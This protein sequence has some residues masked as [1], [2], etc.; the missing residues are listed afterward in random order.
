MVE[1]YLQHFGFTGFPFSINAHGHELFLSEQYREAAAQMHYSLQHPGGIIVLTGE[2]GTGKTTL[3]RNFLDRQAETVDTAFIVNPRMPTPQ[4]IESI[5]QELGAKPRKGGG[6]KTNLDKLHQYLLKARQ[7]DR[8][9][10]VLVDEAQHLTFDSLEQLRLLTNLETSAG[11]LAQIIL[12]GQEELRSLLAHP[13]LRQ[14]RQRVVGHFHLRRLDLQQTGAYIRHRLGCANGSP[15]LIPTSLHRL[16]YRHTTGVPRLINLLCD[17]ALLG[18]YALGRRQVDRGVM[19]Q[20][21]AEMLVKPGRE[22]II[23]LQA[24]DKPATPLATPP[25]QST[26]SPAFHAEHPVDQLAHMPTEWIESPSAIARFSSVLMTVWRGFTMQALARVALIAAVVVPGGWLI[27]QTPGPELEGGLVN[28]PDGTSSLLPQIVLTRPNPKQQTTVLSEPQDEAIELTWVDEGE[29]QA[30]PTTETVE[31]AKPAELAVAAEPLEGRHQTGQPEEQKRQAPNPQPSTG[32]VTTETAKK[33][34]QP[35][36]LD[37]AK[38]NEPAPTFL[39]IFP[40]I[41][42]GVSPL[43]PPENLVPELAK[44]QELP[45][46]EPAP[47]QQTPVQ[48]K[49]KIAIVEPKP[50]APLEAGR[51]AE[52]RKPK[53]DIQVSLQPTPSTTLIDVVDIDSLAD[54]PLGGPSYAEYSRLLELW[55]IE[56]PPFDQNSVP[57]LDVARHQLTCA[58]IT[59]D[60]GQVRAIGL[61]SVLQSSTNSHVRASEF[62][63]VGINDS[64]A[65]LWRSGKHY[66]IAAATLDREWRGTGHY[67]IQAPQDFRSAFRPDSTSDSITWLINAL[68]RVDPKYA[69]DTSIASYNEQLVH[70]VKTFQQQQGLTPDGIA[71]FRTVA[72]L[73][74]LLFGPPILTTTFDQ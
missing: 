72:L 66:R 24:Q 46:A 52:E 67:F 70:S 51:Q 74:Q 1:M 15:T 60:L 28:V 69:L 49:S 22:K 13:S 58:H 63:L 6:I 73:N 55:N 19:K 5:C 29:T 65:L 31:F 23:T 7:K 10:V 2:V 41:A 39:P 8:R 35:A 16:I 59:A 42:R 56:A 48:S 33:P 62:L 25:H 21:I 14:F 45:I 3:A 43:A 53:P 47:E 38:E 27:T 40:D 36:Q 34:E 20:A 11:K 54:L 50:Q 12:V 68:S 30:S 4:L 37:K 26:I 18:A 9:V 64:Y 71:G 57:C 44:T 61:P 17:R 32:A